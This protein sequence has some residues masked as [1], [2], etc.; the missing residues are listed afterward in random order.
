MVAYPLGLLQLLCK[1]L[2]SLSMFLSHLLHLSLVDTAL[3]LHGFLQK[4]HLLLTFGPKKYASWRSGQWC[5]VNTLSMCATLNQYNACQIKMLIFVSTHTWAPAEWLWCPVCP[6]ALIWGLQALLQ[7][8]SWFFQPYSGQPAQI[9]RLPE[10]LRCVPPALWFSSV[11][12]FSELSHPPI[13]N[14]NAGITKVTVDF[15]VNYAWKYLQSSFKS[16]V[17]DRIIKIMHFK[18]KICIPCQCGL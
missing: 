17:C 8:L 14:R 15:C 18:W 4:S 16:Y 11:H 1:L 12:C 5:L 2:Q 10:D 6:P 9:L 7:S 13:W 3:L